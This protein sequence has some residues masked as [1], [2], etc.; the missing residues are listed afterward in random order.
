MN[1]KLN[2]YSRE[3]LQN[4]LAVLKDYR[5]SLKQIGNR[6]VLSHPKEKK[7]KF[8]RV[9]HTSNV[10]KEFLE[11]FLSGVLHKFFPDAQS[12]AEKKFIQND[13][14]IGG[15]RVFY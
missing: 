15:V 4:I 14:I 11:N 1:E 5:T 9:E 10:S 3:D 6:S 12:S 13:K 8:F 2:Q 7:E